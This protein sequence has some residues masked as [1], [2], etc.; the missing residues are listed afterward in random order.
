VDRV[1]E[2]VTKLAEWIAL[3]RS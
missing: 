1:F 3:W 2:F